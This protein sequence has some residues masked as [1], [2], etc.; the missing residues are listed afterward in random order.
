MVVRVGQPASFLLGEGVCHD[1][2]LTL[3]CCSLCF[4]VA[5]VRSFSLVSSNSGS[6]KHSLAP[7][8]TGGYLEIVPDW[9]EKVAMGRTQPPKIPDVMTMMA[10]I[11]LRRQGENRHGFG[12]N[13][14]TPEARDLSEQVAICTI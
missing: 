5:V 3:V 9:H 12:C 8:L 10:V 1:Y 13:K 4:G 7:Y 2:L 11:H 14:S 6:L